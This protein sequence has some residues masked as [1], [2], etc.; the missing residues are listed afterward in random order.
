MTKAFLYD[1]LCG[2]VFRCMF[3]GLDDCGHAQWVK[4]TPGEEPKTL[5]DYLVDEDL[6]GTRFFVLAMEGETAQPPQIARVLGY[7]AECPF[8]GL[9][10]DLLFAVRHMLDL[11]VKWAQNPLNVTVRVLEHSK[12]SKRLGKY[13][14]WIEDKDRCFDTLAAVDGFDT[15]DK[16]FDALRTYFYVLESEAG[17]ACVTKG[18]HINDKLR[19][20]AKKSDLD[21]FGRIEDEYYEINF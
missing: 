4:I 2:N 9:D 14:F 6:E 20:E 3:A 17:I 7:V 15:L 10:V 16:L 18:L 19:K 21:M 12:V 1:S 8:N 13:S 11:G 5:S